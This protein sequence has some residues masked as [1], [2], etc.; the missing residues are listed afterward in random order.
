MSD[1]VQLN[2]EQDRILSI[3]FFRGLTMFM[4]VTG[5]T[6]VFHILADNQKGG[7]VIEL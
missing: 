6:G 1:K 7:A 4:L 5:I 2:Q 3:G